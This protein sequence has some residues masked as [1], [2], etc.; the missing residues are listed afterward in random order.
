V[1]IY[2]WLITGNELFRHWALVMGWTLFIALLMISSIATYSWS[3]IRIRSGW[4]LFALAG[5]ALVGA[6]LIRAPW[7]VLLGISLLYLAVL[8]FSIASYSKV[9]RRR[10]ASPAR[11]PAAAA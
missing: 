8:P 2:L 9:K 10:A 1:P 3:S 7:H 6:A 4:R 11:E 5:V